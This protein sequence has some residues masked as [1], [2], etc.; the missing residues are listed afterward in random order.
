MKLPE[1]PVNW[2]EILEKDSKNVLD[3]IKQKNLMGEI[4]KF[5]KDYFYYS[6][7][8]Y[9]VKEEQTR[10]YIWT[11]MK[12]LRS[13]K[14]E[15]IPFKLIDMYLNPLSDFNRKLHNFDKNLAG[16]IES[17]TK[18]L[19]LEKKYMVSSLMEEAIASSLIE[20][21]ST[22][23]KVA[24]QMLRE[25]RK[26]KNKSE[27]MIV[28][29]YETMQMIIDRKNSKLTADFILEV[30]NMVSKGTLENEDDEGRYRDNNDVVVGNIYT[31]AHIPPN[32]KEIPELIEEL[33][34]FAN[35]ENENFIH[36]ILKGIILHFLIGYIHPFNDGNGRTARSIFYWYVLSKGY[37][38]FEYMSVSKVI[39]RSRKKYDL[40]YLYTEYDEMDLTYFIK[41][42]LNC[43]EEAQNNLIEYITI[44]QK[45]QEQVSKNFYKNLNL[46]LRQ[47][48]ILKEFMEERNKIF[49]IK[50]ISETY[51]VAYQT[52][53]TDLLFLAEKNYIIKKTSSNAFVFKFN[54][55]SS[56][57]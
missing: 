19:N 54:E 6:E 30:Q 41:Y 1:K 42:N 38:L 9:K 28:N 3:V 45:E 51:K 46:N 27:K 31:T 18:S 35:D 21:A 2:K 15:R 36:P 34:K 39:V 49:T 17:R 52:A 24:K 26:P 13:D 22:T 25:R 53:R 55:N 12:L 20:G 32:Y 10:K 48:M 8:K 14:Y 5:N 50:E 7:I 43:I 23:R 11:L 16:N 33:C 29:N 40:A 56:L 47:A 4:F 44:K 57:N 37:W